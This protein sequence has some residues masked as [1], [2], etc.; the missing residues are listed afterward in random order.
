MFGRVPF[1]D[2]CITY[3]RCLFVGASRFRFLLD[4]AISPPPL[5][6]SGHLKEK[7]RSRNTES[8]WVEHLPDDYVTPTAM[9]EIPQELIDTII[10][11]IPLSDHQYPFAAYRDESD[12]STLLVKTLRACALVSRAFVRPTQ[13]RLF[14]AVGLDLTRNGDQ[15]N[16]RFSQLL[17]DRPHLRTYVR[18]LQLTY[19]PA[20]DDGELISQILSSLP[21]LGSIKLQG[22]GFEWSRQPLR[23]KASLLEALSRPHLRHIAFVEVKFTNA[24]ELHALLKTCV[25]MKQLELLG[26]QFV[27]HD[28]LKAETS[29]ADKSMP[30]VL[31]DSLVLLGS[32]SADVDSVLQAFTTVDITRLRF[33]K[34]IHTAPENILRVNAST[35]ERV[36]MMFAQHDVGSN[37]L[38]LVHETRNYM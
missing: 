34:L 19:T 20:N 25:G 36:E 2:A 27:N 37:T 12:E 23:A 24:S 35:V 28:V 38:E 11:E 7:A 22:R 4:V 3:S 33:L 31:L 30:S 17:L 29:T 26:V 14:Y 18:H 32:D 21:C 8:F 5:R 13:I 1:V 10:E 16:G 6:T 9:V 15:S